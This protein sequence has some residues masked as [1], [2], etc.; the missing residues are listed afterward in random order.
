[1]S[2][3]IN[4]LQF[5]SLALVTFAAAT[6]QSPAIASTLTPAEVR[7]SYIKHATLAQLRRWYQIYEN[8][9]TT[10]ENQ[11]EI[12]APGIKLKS[13]LGEASGHDAYKL[14]IAQLPKTWKN[15]HAIT[16]TK[17]VIGAD[18]RID[19]DV[20]LTYLNQGMRPDGTVRSADLTYTTQLQP[21]ATVLP[22]FT[23][24]EIKQL[25]EGTAPAFKDVY[26]DNRLMSL[27]HY[28]LALIEDPK[29]QLEPFK[30]IFADGFELQF[31]SGK[32]TEFKG[33]ETWFRGPASAVAASS[34]DVSNFSYQATGP[35]S[36]TVQMDFDWQGI[37][38]DN[39]EMLA[40]TRQ[41]WTVTDN[42]KERFARIK[43]V[44]VEV[45][46]PFRPKP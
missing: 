26:A 23:Q 30:E 22:Q 29:R 25:N 11:L 43:S 13:G 31:S 17:I 16:G 32:I 46:E 20:A 39:K 34:H 38:P 27:I 9:A 15:A 8:P 37:L 44:A 2:R 12:L 36:Y 41:R 21:T 6:L 10:I 28:W 1:M 19:L 5:F 24:I 14:R 4:R 3:S 18:G 42:P 35:N 33:F 7:Q 45:V 40:K